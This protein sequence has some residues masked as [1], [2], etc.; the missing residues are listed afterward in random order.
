MSGVGE[1]RSALPAVGGAALAVAAAVLFGASTPLIQRAGAGVGP[2]TTAGL[3]YAGA[4]LAGVLS[5]RSQQ[6]EAGI[7]RHDLPRLLAMAAFGALLAP[8]ALAWGLQR[9]SA[10]G[11]S[12]MLAFEAL[13]TALLAWW[14]Y[15]ESVDRRVGAAMVLLLAG[16]IALVFDQG[17]VDAGSAWGLLAVLA[18]TAAWGVDNLLSRKLAERDPGRVVA[19]KAALGALASGAL[20]WLTTEP[21]PSLAA[22]LGLL[23]I[24]ATG[25][26]LSL[27]LY[28]LAQRS[29]T[30]I[31]DYAHTPDG[32][33]RAIRTIRAI[34]AGKLYVLFGAG[35]D[36]DRDK[37]PIMGRLAEEGADWVVLALDN[38]RTED[39]E[40]IFEDIESGMRRGNHTRI[41]DR[42]EAIRDTISKLGRGDCLLLLG[43]GHETYQIMGHEKLPFDER[44]IVRAA[45][46]EMA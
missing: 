20:A 24:G 11:A 31:R 13:F 3:L 44:A 19:A 18:A 8:V 30:V 46:G 15:G 14:A 6:R 43:K 40:R 16:G 12:L 4:A 34:T 29:F 9:T 45:V 22:T 39:P 27:R 33:E 32:F 21:R 41:D 25:Y 23:A 35:G 42:E 1:A 26:G 7:G 38:P 37:R 5:R 36:R 2:F 17:R 10:A 28:L